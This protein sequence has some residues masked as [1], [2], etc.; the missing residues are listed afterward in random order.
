[1]K[2][3]QRHIRVMLFVFA[4]MFV[5]LT[6]YFAYAVSTYGQRWFVNPYNPRL[7]E[8]KKSV[9]PGD[10]RDRNQ[11]VLAKTKDGKRV[12][13]ESA[14]LR[15][16]VSHTVGDSYG[17]SASGAE[18]FQA[19]YLLGFNEN[20]FERIVQ[21]L[22][23]SER[24]GTGVALTIDAALCKFVSE[25]M[26]NNRGAVVVMN[27]ETGEIL[28]SV[29]HPMFDPANMDAYLPGSDKKGETSAL[30]NRATMGRYTPGSVFKIITAAA[31][32]RN[33]SDIETRGFDC[34]GPLAFRKS[35]G[36]YD[37]S[38]II[39]PE[40][41]KAAR[42]AA[43]KSPAPESSPAPTLTD[44]IAP[45]ATP[46]AV[47]AFQVVRESNSA[48]HGRVDFTAAFA[49]SCNVTF[50]RLGMEL[51]PRKLRQMAEAFGINDNVIFPD[52]M[53]YMS[54]F[55]EGKSDIDIAWAAAG[56]YLDT[57]TPLQMCMIS[58]GIANKGVM[59]E[60]R[61]LY[62][63][64]SARETLTLA[65]KPK[66]YRRPLSEAEADKLKE[67]MRA[68]VTNGTGTGA[69]IKNIKVCGKTG[70]AQ[71]SENKQTK[72][73]AWFTGFIDDAKHP[74][75]IAV[76]LEKAG[77]GGEKAAPVAKKVLQKAIE[78]KY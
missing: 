29:S 63:T 44:D 70:S 6:L 57:V 55:T 14:S 47:E 25:A 38:R 1:M 49:K 16:A 7:E 53:L 20:L 32:L 9:T 12:Y 39:T 52:V 4:G 65:G 60:P 28:A 37:P 31:A 77:T 45:G 78:L 19:G 21:S 61:L 27:Y 8:Q 11:V 75:A 23:I 74:L 43:L 64:I 18:S 54:S 41:D 51:G 13:N 15:K 42:E 69:S 5:F 68:V 26:G 40:Q 10:I 17:L 59:M 22:T 3:L 67:M 50:G 56:Q 34:D 72:T 66:V 76:V 2:M 30:V 71:V 24:K 35:D 33:I 36:S 58:A 73:H 46:D 62:G 48:Y